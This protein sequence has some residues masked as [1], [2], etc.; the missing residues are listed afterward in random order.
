MTV[1]VSYNNCMTL[2][3]TNVIMCPLYKG[4]DI[5][6]YLSS[7]SDVR[8]S[9]SVSVQAGKH[10]TFT[11]CGANVGSPSTTLRQH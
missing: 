1:N 5:L 11:Q 7:L 4:G 6:L 10:N 2:L 8:V 9:L 3:E